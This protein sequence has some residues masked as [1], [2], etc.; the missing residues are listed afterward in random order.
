[1][2]AGRLELP[3]P[4][5]HPRSYIRQD[6]AC[7]HFTFTFILSCRRPR[8]RCARQFPPRHNRTRLRYNDRVNFMCEC[9]GLSYSF[10]RYIRR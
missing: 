2:L 3:C 1:M 7:L 6:L 10:M 8:C 4:A 9:I 5:P